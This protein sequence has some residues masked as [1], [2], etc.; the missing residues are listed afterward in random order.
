[1]RKLQ[2]GLT[3]KEID[4]IMIRIDSNNDGFIDYNEFMYVL[5]CN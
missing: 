3:S 2:L 1:M 4:Q 5:Q